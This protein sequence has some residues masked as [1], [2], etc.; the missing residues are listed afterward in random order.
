M[1]RTVLQGGF[2]HRGLRVPL[3]GPQGIFKPKVLP[4][5]PLSITTA[6]SGPYEDRFGADGL[7]RYRYRGTN[8]DHHENVGL[9]KAMATKT[10]LVYFHGILKNRYLAVWPVY[11]V[12][13]EPRNLVFRVAVDDAQYASSGLEVMV[14]GMQ[15]SEVETSARRRYITSTVR[16]RLHQQAFRERVLRAYREQCALCRLRHEKLL[17]AAHIIPDSEPEG[18]PVISNGLA[19]CK[20]HHAAYDS[21][22]LAIRPD[23]VVEVRHDILEEEDGPMLRHG[24]QGLHQQR[25]LLPRDLALRPDPV[26]LAR[27]LKAFQGQILD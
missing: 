24:L 17:D 14:P 20:L 6:P 16:R 10:P 13:D 26:L 3:V 15:V 11:I 27:R 5:I 2:L 19:L 1:P 25:I 18:E 23:Y 4:E 22:F 12:G 8:P 21:L 9:R 7:L